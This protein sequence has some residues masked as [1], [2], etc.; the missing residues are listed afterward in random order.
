ML[1]HIRERLMLFFHLLN[2]IIIKNLIIIY[3]L[4][5]KIIINVI[6]NVIW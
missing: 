1:I 5:Q 6:E 2:K 3:N 4:K